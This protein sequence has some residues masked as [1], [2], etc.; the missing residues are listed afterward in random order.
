MFSFCFLGVRFLEDLSVDILKAW[1]EGEPT[2]R[3]LMVLLL[4]PWKYFKM[5]L[6]LN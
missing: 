1:V 4:G 3:D 6:L 2:Q 5:G